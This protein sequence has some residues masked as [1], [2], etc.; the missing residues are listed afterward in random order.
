MDDVAD[1][2]FVDAHAEGDGG[3]DDLGLVAE[4]G[5]LVFRTLRLVEAGVIGDGGESLPAQGGGEGFGGFAGLAIDDAGVLGPGVGE[6]ANLRGGS[7]FRDDLVFQ[8]RPVEAGEEDGGIAQ[9]ELF[10]DVL[11]HPLGGGGG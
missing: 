7:G 3:A 9:F 5:V 2:G 6:I 8:V 4:E 10:D 1:V 11:A